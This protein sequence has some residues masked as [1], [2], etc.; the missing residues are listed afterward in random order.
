[1]KKLSITTI[2]LLAVCCT[3]C[4][5]FIEQTPKGRLIPE[6]VD[7]MGMILANDYEINVGIGNMTAYSNDVKGL[8][9]LVLGYTQYDINALRFEDYPYGRTENDNDWNRL[10]HSISLCNFVAENIDDAPEGVD[11]L[12]ERNTVKGNALFHRAYSYFLLVNEYARQYNPATAANDPGVPLM[13]Q[14]DVTTV[15]QRSSVQEVYDQII[16][17]ATAAYALLP[18]EAVF[19]FYGTKAAAAGLLA[20]V[21]LFQGKFTA[22]WQEAKKVT[23]TR[24]L[25]DYNN[26]TRKVASDPRSGF[27]NLDGLDWK[28]EE[29][30]YFRQ[31][32]GMFR[33]F[34]FITDDLLSSYDQVNDLRYSLFL[35]T[36][37][38]ATHSAWGMDRHSGIAT[39]EIYLT[40]AEARVRDNDVPVAEV[41]EVLNSFI[42]SRYKT[43]YP[44][45]TETD[46]ALLKERILQERRK[47]MALRGLRLFD[48]KRLYVQ[49]GK[50]EDLVNVWEGKTYTLSAGS[51]KMVM[52]IPLNVIDKSM[53]QQNPR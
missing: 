6:T 30:I 51:N 31:Q 27:N 1:M 8:E 22:S 45:I 49:D 16:K 7:D 18:D 38:F 11:Q 42:H 14:M 20:N 33:N 47:E 17:D 24:A 10:Y 13:L 53:L 43:G 12:H 32:W 15:P 23:Q 29:T 3:A 21:Y 50:A 46:R 9:A 5:K 48:I 19:S 35:T 44:D 34:L 39:G 4:E 36:R 41:L 40:E 28:R 25:K 2:I 26:I 37:L 52:P